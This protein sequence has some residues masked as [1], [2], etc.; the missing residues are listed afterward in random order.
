M[1]TVKVKSMTSKS[2]GNTVPNQFIITTGEG[3]YFQSYDS[4]ITLN[5][6]DGNIYLDENTWDYSRTTLKYLNEFLGTTG[7]K[8]IQSKID[9]GEYKLT[10]LN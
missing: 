9:N 1:L 8:D 6:K 7:K 5:C 2:T 10:N 4:V 3:E